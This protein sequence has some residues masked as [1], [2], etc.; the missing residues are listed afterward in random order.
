VDGA[1]GQRSDRHHAGLSGRQP[2]NG[3]PS[4]ILIII[5]EHLA[6]GDADFLSVLVVRGTVAG[7]PSRD[8]AECLLPT[9]AR[10]VARPLA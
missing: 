3:R 8:P 2:L 7:G 5:F 1:P 4:S 6:G 10:P 9:H